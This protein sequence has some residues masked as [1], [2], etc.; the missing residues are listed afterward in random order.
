[1]SHPLLVE[2]LEDLFHPVLVYNNREGED[3]QILE[4]FEEPAW[5]NP[6]FRVLDARGRDLVPREEGLW[7]EH[8]VAVRLIA[9]LERA[10]RAVPPWLRLV[11]AEERPVEIQRAVFGMT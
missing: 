2:A 6:V 4:R 5:N 8:A 9:G 3:A 7:S 10:G 11:E 1:M